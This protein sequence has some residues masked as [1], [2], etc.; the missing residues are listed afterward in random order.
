MNSVERNS[1]QGKAA[2]LKSAAAAYDR[3]MS[4]DQE[5]VVT[6]DQMEDR[7]LEVGAKLLQFLM[8][9]RLA[10]ASAERH[11]ASSC[12]SRCHKP[13]NMS[14]SPKTRRIRGRTGEVSFPRQQG[15]CPSCRKAF[16]PSGPDVETGR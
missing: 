3:M 15:Y 9:Q 16:F 2:F 5:Q 8:Q 13:L 12:C 11:R 7:A 6:F 10:T 4:E 1:D 14:A